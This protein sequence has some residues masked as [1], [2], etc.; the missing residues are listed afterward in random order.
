MTAAVS[1][2]LAR[3]YLDVVGT[4]L[5]RARS[6]NVESLPA[7]AALVAD[8]VARSGIVYVFGSGHSQLAALDLS[9]RAGSLAPVQVIFEPTW[10]AS[11]GVEGYG[12]TL[13]ADYAFTP[14]DCLIVISNSGNNAA[15]IEVAMAA[16][17][18]GTPV[19]AVTAMTISRAAKPRHSS[20]KKLFELADIV[21]DN[22]G[23]GSDV[24]I[25][26]GALGVGAT[27]TVVGAALLHEVIVEAVSLLVARGLE[28]PVYRA[29]AEGGAGHNALL[30]ERYRGRLKR[31]P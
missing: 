25:K 15:Q 22:G 3:P 14:D 10:G 21:L 8:V 19:V 29:N 12:R 6:A 27:S 16:R 11:E 28:P 1:G 30:R 26:V 31:V 23:V 17:E 7:A 9:N 2:R 24:A 20:G 5:E 13:L 4:V 18:A